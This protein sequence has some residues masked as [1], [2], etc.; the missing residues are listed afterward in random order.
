MAIDPFG[1]LVIFTVYP[2]DDKKTKLMNS[3]FQQKIQADWWSKSFAGFVLGFI[4][5]LLFASI[6]T[7]WAMQHLHPSLAPQ[8]G[9]WSI[10]W[11]WLPLC[12]I[13]F[14]IPK[15]WQSILIFVILNVMAFG[16]LSWMR[17]A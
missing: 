1:G 3:F 16:V 14:F 8:L 11:T 7:L 2:T 5:S 9:M 4:L 15:G 6:I 17:V 13:A 12:F 10:A